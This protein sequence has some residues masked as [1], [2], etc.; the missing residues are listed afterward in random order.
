MSA[1]RP[2]GIS[3][4]GEIAFASNVVATQN[5]IS[6]RGGC[7]WIGEDFVEHGLFPVSG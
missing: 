2:R 7:D 5:E 6:A 4:E 1:A 3:V